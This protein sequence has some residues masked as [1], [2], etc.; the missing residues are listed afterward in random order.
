MLQKDRGQLLKDRRLPKSFAILAIFGLHAKARV[1][2]DQ[3]THLVLIG[4][5]D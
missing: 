2:L 4:E 5:R 3:N 1:H